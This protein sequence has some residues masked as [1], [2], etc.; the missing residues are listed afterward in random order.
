MEI[1]ESGPDGYDHYVRPISGQRAVKEYRCPG[2][3]QVI[4]ARTPHVV[5][6]PADEYGGGSL[7]AERRHWHTGCWRRGKNIASGKKR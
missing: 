5:V 2:C 7:V 4:F 3:N 1:I 6:W